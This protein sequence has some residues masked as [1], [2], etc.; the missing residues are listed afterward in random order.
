MDRGS[1]ARWGGAGTY[2]PL[3]P[4]PEMP[5]DALDHILLSET[6]RSSC[7]HFRHRSG[8]ASHTIGLVLHGAGHAGHVVLDEKRIHHCDGKRA[9]QRALRFLEQLFGDAA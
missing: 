3:L 1:F 8:S 9:E 4:E 2:A 5:Q 6:M 7:E